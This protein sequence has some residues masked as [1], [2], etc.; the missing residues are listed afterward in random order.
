MA[1][2]IVERWLPIPGYEGLYSVS[3]LGRVRSEP[4]YV[5]HYSGGPKWHPGRI[6]KP[7]KNVGGYGYVALNING[8]KDRR[9]VQDLV[10]TAFVG[11]RPE[12]HDACHNDGRR[13]N[14]ALTNLRWDTRSGNMA[15]RDSHGTRPYGRRLCDKLTRQ[16][17]DLIRGDTR[18][19][20]VIAR[21]YGIDQSMVSH[22][23]RGK[24]HAP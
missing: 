24:R 1:D 9:S 22:I 6:L 19:Q 4:R 13:T 5:R 11:P 10:L 14:N 2:E 18:M 3:D 23:K 20:V 15:D 17:V 12:A 21:E 7:V 16:E 8:V